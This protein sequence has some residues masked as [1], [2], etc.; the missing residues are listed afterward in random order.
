MKFCIT[1]I[2]SR[3]ISGKMRSSLFRPFAPQFFRFPLWC[4]LLIL[5][6]TSLGYA[7]PYMHSGSL[8]DSPTAYVPSHG[9]IAI[10]GGA[11]FSRDEER[12]R[13]ETLLSIDLGLMD[14]AAIEMVH[15]RLAEGDKLLLNTRLQML[16]E[17]EMRPA[18]AIGLDH[19]GERVEYADNKANARYR[20]YSPY[21]VLSKR[22]TLPAVQQFACHLGW[23]DRRYRQGGTSLEQLHGFFFGFQKR[24]DPRYSRGY[25]QWNVDVNTYGLHS[26]IRYHLNSGVELQLAIA[27]V[28]KEDWRYW[29]GVRWTNQDFQ[30]QLAET[31]HLARAAAKSAIATGG[32][33]ETPD[34]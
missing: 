23:G 31:K 21:L 10:A 13:Q 1:S 15:L 12:S 20:A 25:I 2:S 6:L 17:V 3:Q 5:I 7:A 28:S 9:I 16:R 24:W 8:V 29:V 27:A 22:F 4:S 34:E 26:G 18:I 14:R 33:A 30:K 32:D 11:V 19:I